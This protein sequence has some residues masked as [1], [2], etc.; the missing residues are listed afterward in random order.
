[1]K[2]GRYDGANRGYYFQGVKAPQEGAR[3]A[4]PG[5]G[6][7]PLRVRRRTAMIRLPAAIV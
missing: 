4:R 3:P 2:A 1:M 6:T 5:G 7:P